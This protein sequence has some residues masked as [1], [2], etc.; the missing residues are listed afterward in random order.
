MKVYIASTVHDLEDIR[1]EV[2]V[3]LEEW[4]YQP[5]L[6]EYSETYNV[7]R[8]INSYSACLKATNEVD[9]FVLIIGK[10]YGGKV[11][12]SS[13]PE[14]Y[15]E[16][17]E[18]QW[19]KRDFSDQDS[20]S[21][22][23]LEYITA[24]NGDIPRINLCR[25]EVWNYL[26]LWKK[27]QSLTFPE[28]F[29]EGPEVMRFLE[30]IRKIEEGKT[31][32]W[33]HRFGTSIDVKEILKTQL[34]ISGIRYEQLQ[35]YRSLVSKEYK[36]WERLYVPL[37]V[38]RFLVQ[39]AERLPIGDTAARLEPE[40]KQINS[41]D[42][43]DA[44][45]EE[46]H[47]VILGEPGSGKSVVLQQI[48]FINASRNEGSTPILVELKHYRGGDILYRV[49]LA[50][51][52]YKL[53]VSKEAV[54]RFLN[55]G[56]CFLLFDGIDELPV[57]Y[58]ADGIDA[59]RDFIV[60]YKKNRIVITCR[61]RDYN[62]EFNTDIPS[63][64]VISPL[65]TTMVQ[66]LLCKYLN[67]PPHQANEICHSLEARIREL[68]SNPQMLTMVAQTYAG[69]TN[70]ALDNLGA[71]FEYFVDS[72]IELKDSEKENF[73]SVVKEALSVI[74]FNMYREGK[75]YYS[76]RGAEVILRTHFENNKEDIRPRSLIMCA[77][78]VG[79]LKRLA[80]EEIEFV[81]PMFRDF[82]TALRLLYLWQQ[83]GDLSEY[84]SYEYDSRIMHYRN[85][86]IEPVGF[87][88]GIIHDPKRFIEQFLDVIASYDDKEKT[89]AAMAA[90]QD[91]AYSMSKN[92]NCWQ[93]LA[94]KL[95]DPH[96]TKRY[97]AASAI[98]VLFDKYHGC[99]IESDIRRYSI[100]SA[101]LRAIKTESNANAMRVLCRA[102]EGMLHEFEWLAC[103]CIVEMVS[104]S[105]LR[106]RVTAA[107]K[108][109]QDWW[110]LQNL[111][112]FIYRGPHYIEWLVY[113]SRNDID[114]MATACGKSLE[115]L[116]NHS[117]KFEESK[118]E[119]ELTSIT[120]QTLRLA[121]LKAWQSE[122]EYAQKIASQAIWLFHDDY[123]L[124][125]AVTV[126]QNA[127]VWARLSF[128]KVMKLYRT[129]EEWEK[130]IEGLNV[131]KGLINIATSDPYQIMTALEEIETPSCKREL[132]HALGHE[133]RYVRKYA[134]RA[135]RKIGDDEAVPVLIELLKDAKDDRE[136]DDVV[137]T[138]KSIGGECT[139]DGLRELIRQPN[140]YVRYNVAYL[141]GEIGGQGAVEILLELVTDS[142]PEVRKMVASVLEDFGDERA[143]QGLQDLLKDENE[144][145]QNIARLV[146][147]RRWGNETETA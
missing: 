57:E 18:K 9:I 15:L 123:L 41:V 100:G 47:L 71:L 138:L 75:L 5:I 19:L 30:R 12:R 140:G 86:W 117:T 39:Q 101:L 90:S 133:D 3:A 147:K 80:R 145:V 24:M 110:E 46:K 83:T 144:E 118:Q 33:V 94:E 32:N 76:Q 134:T 106:T 99:T 111:T 55:E 31:D 81:H 139:L 22:T 143:F 40:E 142:D 120:P 119:Q 103:N 131:V 68:V 113:N 107:W 21:I 135:L 28:H 67:L 64:F 116:L 137:N 141:A 60:L 127:D 108:L 79:L 48:A 78:K 84:L 59:L 25:E 85:K 115:L 6:S 56:R 49:Q 16:F 88:P 23:E 45:N 2:K 43:M 125:D 44:I 52:N 4:G 53:L 73:P 34:S 17:I 42:L 50:L 10:R 136:V 11:P 37:K 62:R 89:F 7:Q 114:S 63:V 87:L 122:D 27:N 93:A 54:Q 72:M 74:A 95:Q 61:K 129:K 104:H 112:P 51:A 77:F 20:I 13:I 105:D 58:R 82:F 102:I 128:V 98:E 1:A 66:D 97:A 91:L 130:Y 146:L 109:T 36:K 14:D 124:P 132:I 70:L 96:D 38:T 35:T 121:L 69:H 65:S 29:K 126:L 26:Q 8:G 92:D